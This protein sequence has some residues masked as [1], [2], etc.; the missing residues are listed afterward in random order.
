MNS[1]NEKRK[2]KLTTEEREERLHSREF[3]DRKRAEAEKQERDY[4]RNLTQYLRDKGE[5]D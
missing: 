2:K 4:H 1:W 5:I 3:L